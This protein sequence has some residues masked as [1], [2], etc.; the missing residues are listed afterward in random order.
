MTNG[1]LLLP[2]ETALIASGAYQWFADNTPLPITER[3]RI[4]RAAS[5]YLFATEVDAL[6]VAEFG[7]QYTATLSVDE[8]GRATALAM[9]VTK[10]AD[11]MEVSANF[12]T[13]A[14]VITRVLS[15]RAEG[16]I[17]RTQTFRIEPGYT[18]EAHPVLFDGLHIAAIDRAVPPPY[19]RPCLW[20]DLLTHETNGLMAARPTVYVINRRSSGSRETFAIT[21]WGTDV[22]MA[23]SLITVKNVGRWVVPTE[24]R[25]TMAGVLYTARLADEQW[26]E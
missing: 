9:S 15:S 26:E 25:F 14:A 23:E 16:A 8:T 11:T 19:R 10:G 18:I 21:R 4:M 7:H 12:E 13:D 24:F 17:Q 6:Q 1:R 2:H 5:G 3:W 22:E 20:L